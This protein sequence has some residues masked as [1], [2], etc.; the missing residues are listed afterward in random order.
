MKKKLFVR[1]KTG[2]VQAKI[3]AS[4]KI[5]SSHGTDHRENYLKAVVPGSSVILSRDN[6]FVVHTETFKSYYW[7]STLH[8]LLYNTILVC[9]LGDPRQESCSL[10]TDA[11][12]K[13]CLPVK[14]QTILTL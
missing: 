6:F 2:C 1:P 7:Q 8:T 13:S 9:E 4:R 12:H 5:D 14:R 3:A 10:V 11:E